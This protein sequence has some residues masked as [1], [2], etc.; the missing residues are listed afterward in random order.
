[1][2][3]VTANAAFELPLI[4][5]IAPRCGPCVEHPN[6]QLLWFLAE[7]IDLDVELRRALRSRDEQRVMPRPRAPRLAVILVHHPSRWTLMMS[8]PR[9]DG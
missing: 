7:V 4:Y 5:R 9:I 6:R 8:D 3:G 1:M 2:D